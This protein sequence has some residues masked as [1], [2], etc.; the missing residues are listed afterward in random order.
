MAR[1]NVVSKSLAEEVTARELLQAEV[2]GL[3][4][5]VGKLICDKQC[6][7]AASIVRAAEIRFLDLLCSQAPKKWRGYYS[8]VCD[9]EVDILSDEAHESIKDLWAVHNNAKYWNTRDI[10]RLL[11]DLSVINTH[12]KEGR[13]SHCR[14][15][16]PVGRRAGSQYI[17]SLLS[18]TTNPPR[19]FLTISSKAALQLH[20]QPPLTDSQWPCMN[21]LKE[22]DSP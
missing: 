4:E 20:K 2:S 3:K 13:S 12:N 17:H 14:L 6:F 9:L 19:Q 8:K 15:L 21:P 10:N 18:T 16:S 5:T 22:I 1:Y 7:K 11:R